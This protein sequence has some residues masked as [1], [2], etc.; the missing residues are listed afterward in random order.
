MSEKIY[1]WYKVWWK[2]SN[3][4]YLETTND[5][6]IYK[7]K[8]KNHHVLYTR[9]K[10]YLMIEKHEVLQ[11]IRGDYFWFDSVFIKKK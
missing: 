7:K 5:E 4:I 9:W 6:H 11:L 10:W 1:K 2:G 8:K 3:D